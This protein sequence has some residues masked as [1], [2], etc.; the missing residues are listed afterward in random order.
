M[1]IRIAIAEDQRM[2][3]ELLSALLGR[4]PDFQ[5]VGEAS[6]GGEA[7]ALTARLAPDVLVLDIGLPDLGGAEVARALRRSGSPAKLLAL[8][9][10]A[11]RHAVQQML[12]AGADGY[13]VKSA[14][15]QELVQA[16]RAVAQ[17]KVYLSP[18]IAREALPESQDEAGAPLAARERQ[19]LALL[20]EGKRSGDIGRALRISPATV[21]AHRRNIMR[22]LGLHTVAELTKYAVRKGLTPL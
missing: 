17:G 7:I 21:E 10:H 6:G 9:I 12:Q 2:M 3:R 1:T 20:A 14:A 16:I 4:E 15:L 19:V 18:E 13:V 5:V 11:E 22:K 8:S